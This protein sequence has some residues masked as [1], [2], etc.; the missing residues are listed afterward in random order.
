M[1]N[2][3]LDMKNQKV[4]EIVRKVFEILEPAG[5]F[6]LLYLYTGIC[7]YRYTL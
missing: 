1:N 3:S 5:G 6:I 2:L 7:T 4:S